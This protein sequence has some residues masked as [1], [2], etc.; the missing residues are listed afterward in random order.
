[1]PP[2]T[3][4]PAPPSSM[5]GASAG[6]GPVPAVRDPH[7]RRAGVRHAIVFHGKSRIPAHHRDGTRSTLP[8]PMASVTVWPTGPG[9]PAGAH[10]HI[11][12]VTAQSPAVAQSHGYTPPGLAQQTTEGRRG[13]PHTAR[14]RVLRQ[15]LG[16]HQAHGLE[17]IKTHHYFRRVRAAFGQITPPSG[18]GVNNTDFL[19]SHLYSMRQCGFVLKYISYIGSTPFPVKGSAENAS[20]GRIRLFSAA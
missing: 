14:R 17:H 3:V 12:A 5:L 1:M 20:S 6:V 7:L 15:P 18:N 2:V 10:R 11:A 16:V 19:W 13:N 8:A 4:V 9:L